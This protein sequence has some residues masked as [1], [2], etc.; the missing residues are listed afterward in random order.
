MQRR[1]SGYMAERVEI[2]AAIS[3]DLQT[4]ITRMRLRTDLMDSE[5]DQRQ[6]PARPRCDDTLV[7]EGVTYARTLHGTTEP[8]RR[9]DADAL[10][11][12]MV[13]DYEDAGQAVRLEGQHRANPS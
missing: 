3:H 6:V 1:I 7:R 13:A 5:H 8:A 11:E 12:S 9:I 10:F 4:P 2:L